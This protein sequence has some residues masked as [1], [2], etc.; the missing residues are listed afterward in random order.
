MDLLI[1]AIF[2]AI[3]LLGLAAQAFGADSRPTFVDPRLPAIS[4]AIR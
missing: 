3:A 2:A 4:N 1:V